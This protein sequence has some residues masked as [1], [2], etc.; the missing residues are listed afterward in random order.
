MKQIDTKNSKVTFKVGKLLVITVKGT[1]SEVNGYINENEGNISEINVNIPIK[2][3]DIE[4]A[5][6][7]EHLLQDDFF[8]EAKY[9]EIQFKSNNIT[10][11]NGQFVAKGELS[12]AG[13]TR[14]V[15]LP[16]EYKNER[17]TGDLK[18]NRL[19]YKLGKLPTFVVSKTVHVS[20][21]CK[22]K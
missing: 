11:K 18:V 7:D 15:E 5:K 16:F 9:P 2:N 6:R 8:N 14:E 1:L 4:S 17:I 3:M 22:V 19:D 12:M 10:Q 20:F 21:D 13:T